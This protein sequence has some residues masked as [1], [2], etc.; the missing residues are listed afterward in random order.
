LNYNHGKPIKIFFFVPRIKITKIYDF[1]SN[2]FINTTKVLGKTNI[3]LL[4]YA[5][6]IA[7][8]AESSY[9]LKKLIAISSTVALKRIE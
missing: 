7:L 8:L 3:V 4:A 2:T 9:E 6:D 1:N 5:D